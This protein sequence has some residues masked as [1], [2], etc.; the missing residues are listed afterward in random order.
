MGTCTGPRPR[1]ST[2][3]PTALS[4]FCHPPSH[5]QRQCTLPRQPNPLKPIPAANPPPPTDNRHSANTP[6]R[7]Q[8]ADR[9]HDTQH[10]R[11]ITLHPREAVIR[12]PHQ[13]AAPEAVILGALKTHGADYTHRYPLSCPQPPTPKQTRRPCLRHFAVG[14]VGALPRSSRPLH[15]MRY[16]KIKPGQATL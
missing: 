6:L 1:Q 12:H 2:R 5:T 16:R 13:P 15:V 14:H 4:G 3:D 11:R 10:P 9:D 7:T 8:S